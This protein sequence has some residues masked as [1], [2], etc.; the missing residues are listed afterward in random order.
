MRLPSKPT[1][2][3]LMLGG[4]MLPLAASAADLQL[5][6]VNG[7]AGSA[8]RDQVTSIHQFSDV[9][10]TDWAYQALRNLVER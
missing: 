2:I 6:A 10:P 4:V 9:R 7:Y 1:S 3:A 8:G 5:D